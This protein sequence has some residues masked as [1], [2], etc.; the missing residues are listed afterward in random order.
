[1]VVVD[2][3]DL[4]LVKSHMQNLCI[5]RADYMCGIIS[6]LSVLSIYVSVFMPVPHCFDDCSFA[7]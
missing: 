3:F 2:I 6:G 5:W 1:M 7:V 4:W